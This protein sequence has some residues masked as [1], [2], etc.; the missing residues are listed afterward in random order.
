MNATEILRNE[1]RVIERVLD[2]LQRIAER[3]GAGGPLDADSA[4]QAVAFFRGFADRCH[5]AKE[6]EHLFPAFESK[7]FPR[8]GGPT[9]VML[10]EHERGRECI[11]G[12]DEALTAAASGEAAAAGRFAH[13]AHAYV[14][15]LREHIMKEDSI[16][17]AMADQ[18]FTADDQQRLIAA[19]AQAE[20]EKNEPGAHEAFL[21]SAEELAARYGLPAPSAPP[22]GHA[23]CCGH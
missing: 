21:R 20:A 22:G 8:N 18:A 19:F 17:F 13:H 4:R 11:A 12:M 5:H 2:V 1:H 10:Y 6:E 14:D 16:L 7:G 23:H 15:L 3:A 9:G